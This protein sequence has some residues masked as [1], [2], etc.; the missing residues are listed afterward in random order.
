NIGHCLTA[1][2]VAGFIK[3]LQAM[4]YKQL[5]PTINFEQLNEHINLEDSPFYVNTE[6]KEWQ[7]RESQQRQAAISS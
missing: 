7:V 4:K 5:P 3:V 6:L 2:G 1:S